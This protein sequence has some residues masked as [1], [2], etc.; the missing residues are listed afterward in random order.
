MDVIF[1]LQPLKKSI[2]LAGPTPRSIDVDSWRPEAIA[3][4]ETMGFDGTVFIPETA[5]WAPHDHYDD[6][7]N[8]EWEALNQSTVVVFWI[9]RDLD[10]MPAFT[11]NVEFGLFAASRKVV[12]GY[13]VESPKNTYLGALAA[14]YDIPMFHS[15]EETLKQAVEQT[16]Q[17]FGEATGK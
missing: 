3:I 14:R 16:R 15:L 11:T 17:R 5:D 4:L 10:T 8:W 9:P 12:L 1:S 7:V 2:F 6:Q 13:P